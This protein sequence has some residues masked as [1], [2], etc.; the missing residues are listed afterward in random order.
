MVQKKGR[1]IRS[2]QNIVLHVCIYL[3]Y[4]ANPAVDGGWSAWSSWTSCS[5]SCNGGF[6]SRLRSCTNPSPSG[7]GKQCLGI[8]AETDPCNAFQCP[9]GFV[10]FLPPLSFNKI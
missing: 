10:S 1:K 5:K 8:S 3:P 4:I 2:S 9:E 6:Q 7:G